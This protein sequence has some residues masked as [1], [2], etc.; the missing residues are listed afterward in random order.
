M[1]HQERKMKDLFGKK[2]EISNEV[3]ERLEN[4]YEILRSRSKSETKRQYKFPKVAVVAITAVLMISTGVYASIRS[5]FFEGMFGNTTKTSTPTQPVS[6]DDGKGGTVDVVIPSKEFVDVDEERANELLGKYVLEEP[7]VKEIG[8]HTLTVENFLYNELG[9]LM[10]FTLEREGKVTALAGNED[11]NL[12]KGASFTDEADFYFTIQIGE[13][14]I[15]YEN[16]YVDTQQSTAEKMYCYS[17]FLWS[18][19]SEIDVEQKPYLLIQKY[20]CTRG[21]I[22]RMDAEEYSQMYENVVEEKVTLTEQDAV[23][24]KTLDL[25][26]KGTLRIS[27]FALAFD[28][29]KMLGLSSL[30]IDPWNV[31]HVEIQYK[32]GESYVVEDKNENINNT[33]Y[34]I[35]CD[36]YYKVAFNRL[37]DVENIKAVVINDIIIPVE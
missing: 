32:N 37:V 14:T 16:I 2:V 5:D 24:T 18:E 13:Q 6:I 31:K 4:T 15:G 11:T 23:P 19:E 34:V 29:P 1:K 30:D 9:G 21:E 36:P 22:N 7:I 3:E 28:I 17:Y 10:Y 33:G 12:T 27:S 26:E 35:G 25:E 20:P 8:S